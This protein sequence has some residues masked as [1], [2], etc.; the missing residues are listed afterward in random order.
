MSLALAVCLGL[1]AAVGIFV[2]NVSNVNVSTPVAE[3]ILTIGDGYPTKALIINTN[4]MGVSKIKWDNVDDKDIY[5]T[6]CAIEHQNQFFILGH[7]FDSF[8]SFFDKFL[9]IESKKRHGFDKFW[10]SNQS[11]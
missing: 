10:Q 4:S 3:H 11:R 8:Y 9:K 6:H 5:F 7:K 1:V 2:N